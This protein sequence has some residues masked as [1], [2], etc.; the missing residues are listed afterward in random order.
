MLGSFVSA[1]PFFNDAV[2]GTVVQVKA[3]AGQL[4][5]LKLVNTTAA[6]AYLQ[7]F[8][9]AAASVVLGTTTPKWTV[10]LAA[11]ESV[12]VPMLLPLGMGQLQP[13]A[14]A[15]MSMAGTTT[16]TGSTGAPVSVS[17]MFE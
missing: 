15:G 6:V 11:N 8:D 10:R 2:A 3:G 17:A 1:Q 7:V 5:Y 13:L 16:P 9:L 4:I 12:S 14:T